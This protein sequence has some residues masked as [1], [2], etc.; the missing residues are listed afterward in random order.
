MLL[1][2]NSPLITFEHQRNRLNFISIHTKRKIL[3]KGSGWTSLII[4]FFIIIP[5]FHSSFIIQ[6]LLTILNKKKKPAQPTIKLSGR[7]IIWCSFGMW[8]LNL[9]HKSKLPI[10]SFIWKYLLSIRN[11][12]GSWMKLTKFLAS[13]MSHLSLGE[14][15]YKENRI[16]SLMTSGI[17]NKRDRKE[18]RKSVCVMRAILLVTKESTTKEFSSILMQVWGQT[19]HKYQKRV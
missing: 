15:E 10:H 7:R 8:E 1:L 4:D 16:Y 13:W 19:T 12:D 14:A 11:E 18:F 2:P 17:V 6:W 3:S 9:L 5:D